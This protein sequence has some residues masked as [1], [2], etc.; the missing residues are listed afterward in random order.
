MLNNCLIHFLPTPMLEAPYE[1]YPDIG[2]ASTPNHTAAF[3]PGPFPG[4][5]T[6]IAALL[7]T[8]FLN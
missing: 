2:K 1:R 7:N 8:A 3:L 4:P 6:A 5:S